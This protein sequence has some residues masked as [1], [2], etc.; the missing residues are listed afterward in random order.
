MNADQHLT[1]SIE[2]AWEK[3]LAD[4]IRLNQKDARKIFNQT[5][6]IEKAFILPKRSLVCVDEGVGD[7]IHSPGS[8]V[9]MSPAE[10]RET[11]RNAGVEEFTTHD[12]CRAFVSAFPGETNPNRACRE[13]GESEASA[14]GIPFRHIATSELN[15]PEDLHIATAIYYDGTGTFTRINGLPMGFVVSRKHFKAAQ[16]DLGLCLEIAFGA[17]GFGNRFTPHRPLHVIPLAHPIDTALSLK[18]LEP[19]VREVIAPFGRRVRLS[20]V[21]TAWHMRAAA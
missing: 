19:E 7:G 9:L 3:S 13:W 18:V 2:E 12:Y 8:G 1:K 14:L 17:Q 21:K 6:D 11:I 20:G 15:R 10:R 16:R 4:I 5:P